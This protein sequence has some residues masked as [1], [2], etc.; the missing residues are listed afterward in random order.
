MQLVNNIDNFLK[1]FERLYRTGPN[2]N[3]TDTYYIKEGYKFVELIKYESRGKSHIIL[4]KI[5]KNTSDVFPPNGKIATGNLN[6]DRFGYEH[7]DRFGV[8]QS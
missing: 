2:H 3:E 8:I 4:V 5:E 7:F 6:T 1:E